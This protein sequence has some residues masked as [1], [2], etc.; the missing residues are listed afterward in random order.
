MLG[1]YLNDHLAGATAGAEL[2]HRMA[3]P[4][5]GGQGVGTLRRLAA[6]ITQAEM[7]Q[8]RAA[9]LGIMADLGI[10]VRRYKV[11]AAWIAEKAGG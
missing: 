3:R 2:V 10:K 9:S 6:E 4:H 1:I 7:T 11:D 5:G 8:D